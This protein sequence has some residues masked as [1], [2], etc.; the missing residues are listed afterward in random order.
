M[1]PTIACLISTICTPQLNAAGGIIGGTITSLEN[2]LAALESKAYFDGFASGNSANI[3]TTARVVP[4]NTVRNISSTDFTLESNFYLLFNTSGLYQVI[5]RLSTDVATGSNRTIA[6]GELQRSIN[7]GTWSSYAGTEAF[8]YNRDAS[9]GEN[10][11]CSSVILNVASG[12]RLRVIARRHAGSDTL[13]TI[14]N[15]CGITVIGL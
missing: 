3:T 6:K 13:R 14:A 7:N 2:R 9:S 1:Q 5:Y 11:A 12:T 10:T 8:C 15:A 4:I